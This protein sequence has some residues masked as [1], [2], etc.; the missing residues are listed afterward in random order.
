[1]AT[2]RKVAS[3][4]VLAALAAGAKVP[5]ENAEDNPETGS[6]TETEEVK[7]DANKSGED[8]KVETDS[9]ETVVKDEPAQPAADDDKGTANVTEKV[10]TAKESDNALVLHLKDEMKELKAEN[11]ELNSQVT[12]LTSQVEAR[13]S[14]LAAFKE[15]ADEASDVLKTAIERLSVALSVNTS[16][17]GKT[18]KEL[19]S[20]YKSLNAKFE[21]TYFVGGKASAGAV[22]ADDDGATAEAV[23]GAQSSL[24]KSTKLH[25]SKR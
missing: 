16:I 7:P 4:K 1:M 8:T 19:T 6:S 18:L 23:S 2:R 5:V 22:T 21:K 13:D 14:E 17:E 15:T 9:V 10:E 11:K 24:I 20:E 25:T 12:T 3:P